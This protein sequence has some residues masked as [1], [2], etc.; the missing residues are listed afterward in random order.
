MTNLSYELWKKPPIPIIISWVFS[1]VE[2]WRDCKGNV[3]PSPSPKAEQGAHR[4]LL[5]LPGEWPWPGVMGLP[6]LWVSLDQQLGQGRSWNLVCIQIWHGQVTH[7][8]Q[9]HKINCTS[10]VMKLRRKKKTWNP[11]GQV[12]SKQKIKSIYWKEHLEVIYLI[13]LLKAATLLGLD[14]SWGGLSTASLGSSS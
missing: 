6:V 9:V 2:M 1:P 14:V 5:P 12:V 4:L 3:Y 13:L 7:N 11:Q 8:S 10:Q